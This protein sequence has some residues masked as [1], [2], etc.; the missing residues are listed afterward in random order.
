[1]TQVE[2]PVFIAQEPTLSENVKIEE[3]IAQQ[4]EKEKPVVQETKNAQNTKSKK[5]SVRIVAREEV[6]VEIE[7]D[8]TLLLSRTLKKGETYDVPESDVELFLKTGNAGGLDI[9]VDGKKIKPLG[10]VGRVVRGVSLSPEKLKK[11]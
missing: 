6:W 3:V 11:R 7:Q 4:I 10:P 2:Q 8:D 5:G 9:L 1:E